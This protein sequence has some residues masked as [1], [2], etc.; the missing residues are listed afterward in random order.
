MV[1]QSMSDV[2]YAKTTLS[3]PI[4]AADFDPYNRGYLVVGGG[5]GE[6]RSGVKNT[7]SVLDVSDRTQ[8]TEVVSKDLGNDE[9]SVQSLANLATKDGLITFA[10]I[11]SSEAQ[12]KAGKNE[13]LR[14]FDINYPPRKKQK[15]EQAGDE[16]IQGDIKLIGQRS[17]FK[18]STASKSEQYQRL[19]RLS[20][21]QRRDTASKRIG[22]VATGLARQNELIVFNATNA[23]PD[24]PDIISKIDLPGEA[25]D[26]DIAEPAPSEFSL[27]YCTDYELYEQTYKY[28]FDTK[29]VE[30]T[31]KGPRRIYEMPA[32]EGNTAR[33][34]FR[35]LRFLNDTN[36]MALVNR[37]NK[38]GA[39]LRIIH[40]YPTGPAA[41][42]FE[43]QLPS[44]V[45]AATGL[46][47]CALDPDKDGN[48]EFVVAVAGQDIS[49]EIYTTNFLPQSQTFT[50][51]A[52]YLTMKNVHEH[53]ITKLLWSPFHSPIRATSGTTGPNGE[54]V[55][56][57]KNHP[58]PQYL[59]L[60]ST[61]FANSVVV[62]TVPLRP[63]NPTDPN[64][65][66]VLVDPSEGP[67]GL[68]SIL[69]IGALIIVVVAFLIQSFTGGFNE[70]STIG[71]FKYLPAHVRNFLDQ[72]ASAARPFG[73]KAQHQVAEIAD[74]VE[75]NTPLDAPLKGRLR[76]LIDRHLKP[77]SSGDSDDLLPSRKALVVKDAPDGS[78]S[79]AVDMHTSKEEYLSSEEGKQAKHWHELSPE[80]QGKWRERLIKAGE[81][82]EGEGEKVLI[83]VLF[84][85]YAG[86]V[87]QVAREAIRE[88]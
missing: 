56:G 13:H 42:I 77:I 50:P 80:Q 12:Q 62:D 53:Q 25:A 58:T 63:L 1:R 60:A 88:L 59:R 79:V 4:Y 2:S 30:K 14:S 21:A 3:Y 23:T 70:A 81:W 47:V 43:K 71:P 33:P 73:R 10:G 38:T 22:A 87:G 36:V 85:E 5:G 66:Y 17:L 34:K 35:A 48:Q 69:P 26:L 19:L 57:N 55:P 24:E 29:K 27:T 39:D 18:P 40:L 78:G 16:D 6:S 67:W 44:R 37:P 45:K 32:A 20:P 31:P 28:D 46:D 83:G 86:A 68:V 51:F 9:D 8:I 11:N 61:S 82:A 52:K 76:K 41:L 54:P 65:R 7:I 75:S 74:I 15:V 84:S 64:S 49:I 72:P